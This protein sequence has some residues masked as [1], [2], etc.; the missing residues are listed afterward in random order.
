MA[1]RTWY[2]KMDDDERRWP[3]G[4]V[5][6]KAVRSPFGTGNSDHPS[7]NAAIVET[8]R[9]LTRPVSNDAPVLTRARATLRFRL[10]E[11]HQTTVP[12]C[13]AQAFR[14][15][16]R[17]CNSTPRGRRESS[18]RSRTIG[19]HGAAVRNRT[20]H[21]VAIEPMSLAAVSAKREVMPRWPPMVDQAEQLRLLACWRPL[22]CGHRVE[23]AGF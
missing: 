10:E 11:D 8:D 4:T 7:Q 6:S 2:P 23:R 17:P 18:R 12:V 13:N 1:L 15:S 5:W 21:A 20:W 9:R 19:F 16:A 22:R 3:R 14:R